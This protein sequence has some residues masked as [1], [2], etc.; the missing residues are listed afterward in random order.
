MNAFYRLGFFI[1]IFFTSCEKVVD[2]I[3][4]DPGSRLVVEASIEN[5]QFPLVYLSRSL[6]FFSVISQAELS[7][8][9]VRNAIVTI[10]GAGK[11]Q[12]LKEYENHLADG[13][14][15]FYY[16][17]DSSSPA[18]FQGE[19]GKKYT[20]R[21]QVADK[22]YTAETT[23]PHLTKKITRLFY[24]TKVDRDDSSKVALY[25]EFSDPPGLGN[26]TRYFTSVNGHPYLPGL[27]SVLDDQ[28]VDGKIYELQIEKGVD[29]NENFSFEDYPF[30]Y[31]GSTV[32]IKYCNIDK[33]VFDFW[34]TMEY[35]YQSIGN[36]F[37]SPTRI[38]GNISNN[39]L[40]YFGGYAVQYVKID[41]PE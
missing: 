7:G 19:F 17:A 39:A 24:Q 34:S 18:A 8:S 41:I 12:V 11:T 32:A 30:F 9:F 15:V 29:R 16:T 22:E 31:K 1:V 25:G 26:Y 13:L 36:P 14:S 27:N 5:G 28:I 38:S 37:S 23:I 4:S 3:P 20:L 21:V 10:S 40:G 6:N 35:A 33:A 2:F